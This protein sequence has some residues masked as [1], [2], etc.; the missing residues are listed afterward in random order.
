MELRRLFISWER[1]RVRASNIALDFR[2]L[3]WLVLSSVWFASLSVLTYVARS[4]DIEEI[5]QALEQAKYCAA[6]HH[7]MDR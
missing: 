3:A 1:R 6:A 4:S 7:D 2:F 5:V